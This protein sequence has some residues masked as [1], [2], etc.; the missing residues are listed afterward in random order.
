MCMYVSKPYSDVVERNSTLIVYRCVLHNY[1][2][3]YPLRQQ[4][5]GNRNLNSNT[6]LYH[7]YTLTSEPISC[8]HMNDACSYSGDI[9]GGQGWQTDRHL[10]RRILMYIV[11]QN[12][13]QYNAHDSCYSNKQDKR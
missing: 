12:G 1:V 5:R 10:I 9:G 8:A 6:L 11:I 4:K 2:Y 7:N 13:L 3:V